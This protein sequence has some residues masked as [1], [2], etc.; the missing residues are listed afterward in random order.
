MKC[1]LLIKSSSNGGERN[2]KNQAKRS[3]AFRHSPDVVAPRPSLRKRVSSIATRAYCIVLVIISALCSRIG[4]SELVRLSAAG[5]HQSGCRAEHSAMYC[6][7]GTALARR[8]LTPGPLL[9]HECR[10][11]YEPIGA[12]GLHASAPSLRAFRSLVA[13]SCARVRRRPRHALEAQ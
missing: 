10:A 11:T 8:T 7:H 6:A 12:N 1:W 9:P 3:F 4:G 5:M 13:A 2:Q